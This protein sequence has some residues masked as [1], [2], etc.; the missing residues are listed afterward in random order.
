[1][2][3]MLA[4]GWGGKP[5]LEAISSSFQTR[6]AP[7]PIR[8]GSTNSPKEKWCLALSQP[9]STAAS[10]LNGLHSIIVILRGMTL[11]RP[12]RYGQTHELKIEIIETNRFRI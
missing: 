3:S 7:Q 11:F 10:W 8:V 2:I 5:V 4:C 1:M 9:W 6:R 12:Q